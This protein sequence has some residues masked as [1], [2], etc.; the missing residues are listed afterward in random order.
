MEKKIKNLDQMFFF[1]TVIY[2]NLFDDTMQT[3][4]K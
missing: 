4:P 1:L 2:S 3:K